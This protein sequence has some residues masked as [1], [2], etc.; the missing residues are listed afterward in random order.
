[1]ET[2]AAHQGEEARVLSDIVGGLYLASADWVAFAHDRFWAIPIYG[3]GSSK[4]RDFIF[5]SYPLGCLWNLGIPSPL[6]SPLVPLLGFAM[7][8]L[9]KVLG[10]FGVSE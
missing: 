4:S 8:L 10:F 5:N 2:L 9:S 6:N 1:M 3:T 7:F